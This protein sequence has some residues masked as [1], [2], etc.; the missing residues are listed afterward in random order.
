MLHWRIDFKHSGNGGVNQDRLV[1]RKQ[2]Y[3]TQI[4]NL[5][6]QKLESLKENLEKTLRK[7]LV[8]F[9]FYMLLQAK[10]SAALLNFT[11]F[12]SRF[13]LHIFEELRVKLKMIFTCLVRCQLLFLTIR[14][15]QAQTK[16]FL[17]SSS[18]G[19]L[20]VRRRKL[21]STSSEHALLFRIFNVMS[22]ISIARF[23]HAINLTTLII[24]QLSF[25]HF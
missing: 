21:P 14:Y 10:F 11:Y 23:S 25:H 6:T 22:E 1:S 18:F 7:T 13:R 15:A 12:W 5:K 9:F 17:P 20:F 4:S 8:F 2:F 24:A 16:A 19:C 3:T